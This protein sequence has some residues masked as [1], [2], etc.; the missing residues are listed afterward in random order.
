MNKPEKIET[1]IYGLMKEARRNG[2]YDLF[3]EAWD[4]NKEETDKC[5]EYLEF[6]LGF[7]I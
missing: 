5:I 3:E 1:F 2:L 4:M 6:I 7:K